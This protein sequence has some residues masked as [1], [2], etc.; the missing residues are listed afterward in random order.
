MGNTNTQPLHETKDVEDM[1]II[2]EKVNPQVDIQEQQ[3][4][5]NITYKEIEYPT[6]SCNVV[7]N[8]PYKRW[9]CLF[10]SFNE[11]DEQEKHYTEQGFVSEK[12]NYKD[13]PNMNNFIDHSVK[14]YYVKKRVDT[15]KISNRTKSGPSSRFSPFLVPILPK[16]ASIKEIHKVNKLKKWTNLSYFRMVYFSGID[17][18]STRGFLSKVCGLNNLLIIVTTPSNEC[19][20]VFNGSTLPAQIT[21]LTYIESDF[22][23][24]FIFTNNGETFKFKRKATSQ[25]KRSLTLYPSTEQE[26]IFCAFCSF[27]ITNKGRIGIHPLMRDQFDLSSVVNPLGGINKTIKELIV[28]HCY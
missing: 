9:S 18:L 13:C 17:E 8:N 11:S 24:F 26:F 21:S 12:M 15:K 3:I 2:K 25:T 27:W 23:F 19:F 1:S 7:V 10:H 4:T 28:V 20:G 16:P 14:K 6:K 22:F 5:K